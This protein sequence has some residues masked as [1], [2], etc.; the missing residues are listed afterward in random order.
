MLCISCI[1]PGTIDTIDCWTCVLPCITPLQAADCYDSRYTCGFFNRI[2]WGNLCGVVTRCV[3]SLSS[4]QCGCAIEIVGL[5]SL[6]DKGD[7]C[8]AGN[9]SVCEAQCS[10]TFK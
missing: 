3:A 9:Q 5:Y 4:G 2:I 6:N 7:V 10:E 8:T 1:E